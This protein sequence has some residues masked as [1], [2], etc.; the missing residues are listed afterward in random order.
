VAIEAARA[1]LSAPR[2]QL[3]R[4]RE[5]TPHGKR[6]SECEEIADEPA[7]VRLVR[8]RQR[9]AREFPTQLTLRGKVFLQSGGIR[10]DF[11]SLEAAPSSAARAMNSAVPS[12][13]VRAASRSAQK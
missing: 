10:G 6:T 3:D 9:A 12:V 4:K 2:G 7:L 5:E 13:I 8:R 1:T 11:S